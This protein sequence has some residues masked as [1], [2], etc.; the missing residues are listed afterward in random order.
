[1][2][3]SSASQTDPFDWEPRSEAVPP[4]ATP[5]VYQVV[6]LTRAIKARLEDIGRVAVEGEVTRI[7]TAASGHVYFDLKDIDAKIACTIWKS[8]VA[9]AA[10]FPIKEGQKVVAHGKL[11]VYAPRGTYSLNVQRL[12][13]A[14]LGALLL[15][16]EERR[17][18]LKEL[19]WFERHRP[20]P[21]L[22]RVIGVATSRDG[23]AFQDFLRTR[24]LR[25]PL[26]PV[27]LAHTSVQ[28]ASAA[29]EIASAIARLDASGVDVIVVCRGG[30]SLEDL[31][32]FNEMP[33]LEAVRQAR[34]PV[35]SGVGHETDTTL[36]DLVADV[37]AHTPTDAA[38]TVIPDRAALVESLDRAG[39]ELSRA[40]DGVFEVRERRLERAGSSPALR[41][42]RW[43]LSNRAERVEGLSRALAGAI[44]SRIARSG[45]RVE[46][47]AARL[48]RQSPQLALARA[49]R[50]LDALVPRL[51]GAIAR[52]LDARVR[53]LELCERSLSATSPLSV[54]SRGYSITRRL[55]GAPLTDAST[56]KPGDA[57]ETRLASGR[58]VSR[59]ES[60]LPSEGEAG[61]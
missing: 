14:G 10:R 60:T 35:V 22:P 16:L 13:P 5:R 59:V 18:K 38:Q 11:D 20:L 24:S 37:R 32:A 45:T 25:W 28:G 4:A 2:A 7:T 1:M 39:N 57:L 19:G 30:G 49:Q 48:A 40:I 34:V 54:L 53:R 26:Y 55:G 6:E 42:P 27:R 3:R 36:C 50:R 31:W 47:T 52:P 33:V 51:A 41:D 43:I 8:A 23:A 56:L 12:E 61:E 9:T 44:A 15:Q 17:Q 58:V 29:G 46:Q 21:P